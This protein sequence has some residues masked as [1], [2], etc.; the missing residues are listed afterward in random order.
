MLWFDLYFSQVESSDAGIYSC[1]AHNIV[2]SSGKFEIHVSVK[3][4]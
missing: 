1:T 2:G 3:G 4:F